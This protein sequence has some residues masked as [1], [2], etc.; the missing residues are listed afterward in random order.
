MFPITYRYLNSAV[1]FTV[2]LIVLAASVAAGPTEPPGDET[3]LA[4]VERFAVMLNSPR[5]EERNNAADALRVMASEK[6][7]EASYEL[8]MEA[9]ARGPSNA[10]GRDPGSRPFSPAMLTSN[11]RHA[12][13]VSAVLLRIVPLMLQSTMPEKRKAGLYLI[14]L[15]A[16][17]NQ[18]V[19]T[20]VT[21]LLEDTDAEVRSMAART[22]LFRLQD[23]PAAQ[24]NLLA[25][26]TRQLRSPRIEERKAALTSLSPFPATNRNVLSM[27]EPLLEDPDLDF[28]EKATEALLWRRWDDPDAQSNLVAILRRQLESG[29][30]EARLGAARGLAVYVRRSKAQATAQSIPPSALTTLNSADAAR[31]ESAPGRTTSWR[32]DALTGEIEKALTKAT[33]DADP[34]VALSATVT[35]GEFQPKHEPS[36]IPDRLV[37]AFVRCV[38]HPDPEVR[39]SGL[40]AVEEI[41][42]P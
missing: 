39:E 6:W 37:A 27:L 20:L 33:G 19:G 29:D 35:L 3:P 38:E 31:R 2:A 34:R 36:Q 4:A 7:D 12:P 14:S 13:W 40:R 5:I 26:A 9:L 16:I 1:H 22:I 15:N 21:P 42:R 28:R 10:V 11:A 41:Q 17:T 30:A 23:D 18:N 24:S 8:A 32:E 25:S